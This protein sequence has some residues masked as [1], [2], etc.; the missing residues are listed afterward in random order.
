M[1]KFQLKPGIGNLFP[2]RKKEKPSQPDHNG[3]L[4]ADQDYKAG[5]EIKLSGWTKESSYG[6]FISISVN[7]YK[8]EQYPKPVIEDENSVPF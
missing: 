6:Q 5:D 2:N 7:N 1:S 4:I 8:K 3:V